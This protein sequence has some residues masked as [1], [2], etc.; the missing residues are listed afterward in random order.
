MTDN[1]L[2][3]LEALWTDV[4]DNVAQHRRERE[5][6]GPSRLER[7]LDDQRKQGRVVVDA[8]QDVDAVTE[9]A[10]RIKE[11]LE[12]GHKYQDE[13]DRIN[14]RISEITPEAVDEHYLKSM[15][16]MFPDGWVPVPGTDARP[17]I[18]ADL[19]RTLAQ[20]GITFEK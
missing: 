2:A 16:A 3:A 7:H 19:M 4:V 12:A 13:I 8:S 1:R 11:S 5:V 17:A 14:Q 10:H 6:L 20:I 9:I 15:R 18:G